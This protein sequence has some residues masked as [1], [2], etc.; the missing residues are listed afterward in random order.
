M[1]DF[2]GDD[3]V[4]RYTQV[5]K[6]DYTLNL[7]KLTIQPMVKYLVFRVKQRSSTLKDQYADKWYE[8][9][10]IL[11]MNYKITS[12]T[13]L[14]LGQ[15]GFGTSKAL[16]NRVKNQVEGSSTPESL[17]RNMSLVML[18][19]SSD[20]WGYKIAANVGFLRTIIDYDAEG[21]VSDNFSQ[22]FVKI[23]CGY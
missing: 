6:L 17:R 23:V 21:K 11:R 19:N 15:Q 8:A 18:S 9:A 22:F 7:G 13:T 16:S 20:Y 3:R 4:T 2:A 14:Q 5:S 1:F 10:P 12:K